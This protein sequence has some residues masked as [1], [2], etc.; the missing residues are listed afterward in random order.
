M[1]LPGPMGLKGEPGISSGSMVWPFNLY[2]K[3]IHQQK[4]Q[5]LKKMKE[6]LY[7]LNIFNI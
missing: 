7:L 5:A 2:K 3:Y 1:G 4:P 6:F